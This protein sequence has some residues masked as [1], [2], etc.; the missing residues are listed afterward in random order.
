MADLHTRY[1]GLVEKAKATLQI[2]VIAS[3]KWGHPY[4]QRDRTGPSTLMPGHPAK[5]V[6]GGEAFPLVT[7]RTSSCRV[8]QIRS[9]TTA[10]TL[11]P[12][13]VSLSR[14]PWPRSTRLWA[15]SSSIPHSSALGRRAERR[16]GLSDRRWVEGRSGACPAPAPAG[17]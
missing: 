6:D 11:V 17:G 13:G 15:T 7:P 14:S 12:A 10:W 8:T 9:S 4:D 3:L 5:D 16:Q 1:L 2:P